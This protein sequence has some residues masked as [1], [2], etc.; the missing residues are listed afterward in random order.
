MISYWQEPSDQQVFGSNFFMDPAG[1]TQESYSCHSDGSCD[2]IISYFPNEARHHV[3][4][5][6]WHDAAGH[7]KLSADYEYELDQFG[8]LDEAKGAGVEPGAWRAKILRDGLPDAEELEGDSE[9]R[10]DSSP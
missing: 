8:N 7:L 4:R 9:V 10:S 5:I 3:S 2:H 6:E 1:K